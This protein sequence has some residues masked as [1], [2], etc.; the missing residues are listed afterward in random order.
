MAPEMFDYCVRARE[1]E[2][3]AICYSRHCLPRQLLKTVALINF[4]KIL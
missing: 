1:T 2:A 4:I 3:P